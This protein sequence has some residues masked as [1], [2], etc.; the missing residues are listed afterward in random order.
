MI[1]HT[2]LAK[3]AARPLVVEARFEWNLGRTKVV[4]R[5]RDNAGTEAN[6]FADNHVD[7]MRDAAAFVE[8]MAQPRVGSL[9]QKT[10]LK[11]VK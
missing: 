2:D 7:A 9:F 3:R 8:A 5:V 10:G 11:V 6:G 4:W 1:D